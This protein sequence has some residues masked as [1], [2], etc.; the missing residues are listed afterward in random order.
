MNTKPYIKD[1]DLKPIQDSPY[2]LTKHDCVG[3]LR[4]QE[5]EFTKI[6]QLKDVLI[7]EKYILKEAE[8]E[9]DLETRHYL[10]DVDCKRA[11]HKLPEY[12]L[13][14]STLFNPLYGDQRTKEVFTSCTGWGSITEYIKPPQHLLF[15]NFP[16][17]F[18]MKIVAYPQHR[19][20]RVPLRRRLCQF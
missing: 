15:Q 20:S 12:N 9:V 18:S 4:R 14:A 17:K 7:S 1:G 10:E 11:S 3:E 8:L 13:F 2:V 19:M 5:E 6:K 16:Q